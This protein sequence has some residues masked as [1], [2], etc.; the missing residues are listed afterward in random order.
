MVA[1]T[2]TSIGMP[3]EVRELYQLL[4]HATGQDSNDLMVE[5]L[6][7]EGQR[8]LDQIAE[9]LEGGPQST[10]PAHGTGAA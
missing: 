7:V 3:E 10:S 8:R 9:I 4:A 5:V 6:R 2:T 1:E